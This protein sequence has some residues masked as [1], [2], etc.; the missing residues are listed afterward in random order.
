MRVDEVLAG[1]IRHALRF[2]VN[3][4]ARSYVHPAT[5]AAG[6]T[7]TDLPPLGLR[8][9]LRASFPTAGLSASTATVVRA[10]QDYGL[11]LADNGSDWYLT[12]DSDDRWG[13]LM[14]ALVSELRGVHGSDFEVLD[15][16]PWLPQ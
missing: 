13:P 15:T 14:D 8:V 1:E 5:H 11:I 10:M 16:G 2:T 7:G 4:T 12:G 3:R 9:R 6:T